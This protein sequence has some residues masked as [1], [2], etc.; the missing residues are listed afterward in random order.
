MVSASFLKFCLFASHIILQIYA[1]VATKARGYGKQ[2]ASI[3]G[4]GGEVSDVQE[5]DIQSIHR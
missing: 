2:M 5:R 1:S 4:D 3:Y